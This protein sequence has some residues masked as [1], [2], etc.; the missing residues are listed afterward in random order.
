MNENKVLLYLWQSP[1]PH[2]IQWTLEMYFYSTIAHFR[3]YNAASMQDQ[4]L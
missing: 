4:D 2:V 3:H 1:R